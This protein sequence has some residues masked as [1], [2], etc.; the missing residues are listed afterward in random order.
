MQSRCAERQSDT[1]HVL[2]LLMLSP[3][4]VLAGLTLDAMARLDTDVSMLAFYTAAC[5]TRITDADVSASGGLLSG[6][7]FYSR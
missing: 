6:G 7:H 1:R 5:A 3:P 2:E 4:G